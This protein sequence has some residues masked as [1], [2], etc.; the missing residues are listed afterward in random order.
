MAIH[1]IGDLM[2]DEWI[3]GD[4]NRISPEAPVPVVNQNKVV[5]LADACERIDSI[6]EKRAQEAQ[7]KAAERIS[8]KNESLDIERSLSSL[9]RAD[10]RLKLVKKR[11]F[12]EGFKVNKST[13]SS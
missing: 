12:R 13:N 3:S 4:V 11:K 8:S 7:A 10:L 5:I 9:R 6:N 2:L 1:V